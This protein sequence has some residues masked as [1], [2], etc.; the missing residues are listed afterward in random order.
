MKI[1]WFGQACF[2][3]ITEKGTVILCDPYH[4]M[5]GYAAHPRNADIVTI[6]HEHG[7]HNH[8]GWILG[9]PEVIRGEGSREACGIKITGLPSCHDAK[10]GAERGSNTIFILEADGLRLCH[11]GDLG[12][13]PDAELLDQIGTPDVVFIPAGGFYTFEPD[14]AAAL[15]LKIGARLTIPMHYKTGVKE[16]PLGTVEEFARATS[17][18]YL[19][20]S[21]IDFGRDYNGPRVAIFDYLR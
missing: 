15:A 12:H 16:T 9:T 10:G 20:V 11:L 7:D 8:T 13:E 18:Q 21:S 19:K 3:I 17:A 6:S 14:I 2:E 5:T 4:P 1:T